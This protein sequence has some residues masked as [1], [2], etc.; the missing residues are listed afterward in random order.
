[1]SLNEIQQRIVNFDT[2]IENKH[3]FEDN[4][5]KEKAL[6]EALRL[7]QLAEEQLSNEQSD[8]AIW[9]RLIA[10]EILNIAN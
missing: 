10:K 2:K 5:F 1:M 3:R 7:L 6:T 9:N 4:K 8:D